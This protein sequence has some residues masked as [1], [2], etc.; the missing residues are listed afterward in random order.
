MNW[1]QVEGNWK[2]FKGKLQ[3]TWGDLTDDQLDQIRGKRTQLA[4][5]I[6]KSYGIGKDEAEAQIK[7]FEDRADKEVW[8]PGETKPEVMR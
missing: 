2:I 6:Q 7:A 1:D 4:G 3:E 8:F 5:E